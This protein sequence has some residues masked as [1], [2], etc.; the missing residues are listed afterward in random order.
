MTFILKVRESFSIFRSNFF[1]IPTNFSNLIH[2]NVTPSIYWWKKWRFSHTKVTSPNKPAHC[3]ATCKFKQIS[4]RNSQ[5]LFLNKFFKK[6]IYIWLLYFQIKCCFSFLLVCLIWYQ[7]DVII[8]SFN[9]IKK[10]LFNLIGSLLYYLSEF[11][12]LH[13]NKKTWFLY[14]SFKFRAN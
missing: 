8:K 6:S 13:E 4:F 14:L 5:F 1:I 3:I 2:L 9:Y 10:W 11:F 7:H 12:E